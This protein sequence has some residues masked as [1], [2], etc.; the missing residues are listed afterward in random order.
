MT[1]QAQ[2]CWAIIPAKPPGQGKTRL[3]GALDPRQRRALVA[4]MLERVVAAAHD[5]RTVERVWLVGASDHDLGSRVSRIEDLGLGLN[6]SLAAA[7]SAITAD[8]VP[9]ARVIVAAGDLPQVDAVDF[10]LLAAVPG[11][12]IGI[13]PDRHGSG[14][15]ALSLPLPGAAA[16]R[17]SFGTGSYARHRCEAARLGYTVETILSAGLEKDIDEPADLPDALGVLQE[18]P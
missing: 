4:G 9:P 17:F 6:A 13:A 15:N 18:A 1:G 7:L 8:P 16:F 2:A 5:C 10:A 14:T 12:A 3:A 11:N